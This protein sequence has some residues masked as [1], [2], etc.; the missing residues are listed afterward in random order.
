MEMTRVWRTVLAAVLLGAATLAY[1]ATPRTPD[2][3][4]PYAVKGPQAGRMVLGIPVIQTPETT[5]V[6]GKYANGMGWRVINTGM[7]P[8][9]VD[10]LPY[11]DLPHQEWSKPYRGGTLKVLLINTTYN[12]GEATMLEQRGDLDVYIYNVPIYLD[13]FGKWEQNKPLVDFLIQRMKELLAYN[14]D[15]ILI[16]GAMGSRG[17][18][19]EGGLTLPEPLHQMVVDKVKAGAGAVII[20]VDSTKTYP[21]GKD[22]ISVLSPLKYTRYSGRKN[23]FQGTHPIV[24]GVPLDLLNPSYFLFS[25]PMPGAQVPVRFNTQPFL[26]LSSYGEG[27]VAAFGYSGPRCIPHHAGYDGSEYIDKVAQRLDDEGYHWYEYGYSLL[28]KAIL[29]AGKREP[30]VLVQTDAARAVTQGEAVTT[31]LALTNG[32][33]APVTLTLHVTVRNNEYAVV[34]TLAPT[35]TLAA[36][37]KKTVPL[38]LGTQFREGLH[39]ADVIIRNK[40]RKVEN[41]ASA[42]FTVNNGITL[43]VQADKEFYAAGDTVTVTTQ[44]EP[45]GQANLIVTTELWDTFGRLLA[46]KTR[47][48]ANAQQPFTDKQQFSLKDA[49]AYVFDIKTIIMQGANCLEKRSDEISI[50]RYEWGDDWRNKMWSSSSWFTDAVYRAIGI[51][52]MTGAA[53]AHRAGAMR[54]SARA[55]FGQHAWSTG[56]HPAGLYAQGANDDQHHPPPLEAKWREQEEKNIVESAKFLRKYGAVGMSLTGESVCYYDTSYDPLTLQA[57]KEFVKTKY[58]TPDAVNAQWGTQ[59][60]DWEQ[61]GP[62]KTDEWKKSGRT[63]FSQ[64]MEFRRFMDGIMTDIQA[65]TVDV[66]RRELGVPLRIGQEQTFGL[67]QHT[68]PY[69]GFDYYAQLTRGL[70]CWISYGGADGG[71]A[72]S[73]GSPVYPSEFEWL[74]L[75]SWCKGP[76][77]GIGG[78]PSGGL[79]GWNH[80]D[81]R[82][83]SVLLNGGSGMDWYEPS[84]FLAGYG[85]LLPGGA[86]IYRATHEIKQG[87][88]KTLI[89][90]QR[91]SDPVA[92]WQDMTNEY[93]GWLLTGAVSISR[94]DVVKTFYAH[95]IKPVAVSDRQVEAGALQQQ[96]IKLL[97]LPHIVCV[98]AKAAGQVRKFVEAG[99]IVVADYGAGAFDE[100]GKPVPTG[101]LDDLFGISRNELKK[102]KS[103][104]PVFVTADPAFPLIPGDY[105]QSDHANCAEGGL[106][107]TTGKALGSFRVNKDTKGP[108]FILNNLGKG[109]ALL[110]NFFPEG[111]AWMTKIRKINRD[112]EMYGL[113]G[114]ML[115]LAGVEPEVRITSEGK[116]LKYFDINRFRRGGA[117]YIGVLR[118]PDRTSEPDAV[119][120]DLPAKGHL[121]ELRSHRYLGNGN[122]VKET[123]KAGELDQAVRVY[124][125]LPYQ[126]RG[127]SLTAAPQIKRGTVLPYS[128]A[129]TGANG[130]TDHVLRIEVLDPRNH[131][132]ACYQQKVLA[133]KGKYQGRLPIALNDPVG[134]WQIK[135]TD[136]ISGKVAAVDLRVQE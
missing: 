12:I 65:R 88:G 127:V 21:D 136:V 70:N 27:R 18:S 33:T 11:L 24:D 115:R 116:R 114:G 95:G 35:V 94:W 74:L 80:Y 93:A 89:T 26:A 79:E 62:I 14:P 98:S 107:V 124:A 120:I 133:V 19:S 111:Y 99:G 129:I 112:E 1:G 73:S 119:T 67:W 113:V 38:E 109:R 125:I 132:P 23:V 25:E 135:V 121:Y 56:P 85:A 101:Y 64:W 22:A 82:S 45:A 32:D 53:Y 75:T 71:L 72:S 110:L 100:L 16:T 55:N 46:V 31:N 2:L 8:L 40:D 128:V 105:P 47:P 5:D 86:A 15:V 30:R 7:L 36:G 51:D 4:M 81:G 58:K 118:Y 87:I 134:N 17:P 77:R 37:E 126:V 108:A 90:A 76:L 131:E 60:T 103:A 102:E 83:W 54:R 9:F 34:K 44:V 104:V 52:D 41:W 3:N 20:P 57:F 117:W 123:F 28:L 49:V 78:W 42:T 66:W 13:W 48:I 96:G 106:Q 84:M 97:Y 91:K 50:P 68:I 29:W 39:L 63:N 61:V 10:K 6:A 59:Y 43:T 130:S 92:I 69:G 122:Q